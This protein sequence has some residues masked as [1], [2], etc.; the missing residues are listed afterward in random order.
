MKT[1]LSSL[2]VVLLL[3]LAGASGCSHKPKVDTTT[4]EYSVQAADSDTQA[5]VTQAIEAI[6][7]GNVADAKAK[8]EKAAANPKLTADQ[9][10]AITDV[11]A[12][13]NK[14]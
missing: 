10:K 12:Q 8:L 3:A 11:V 2:A 13:L 9:K 7:K 5:A 1:F 14:P 6:D 4:L